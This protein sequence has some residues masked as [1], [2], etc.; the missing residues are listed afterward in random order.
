M[1]SAIGYHFPLPVGGS[2]PVETVELGP[3]AASQTLRLFWEVLLEKWRGASPLHSTPVVVAH[4]HGQKESLERAVEGGETFNFSEVDWMSSSVGV[5]YRT[6]DPCTVL[7]S[8]DMDVRRLLLV[9]AA[10]SF[11]VAAHVEALN[12]QSQCSD[13]LVLSEAGERIVREIER[14]LQ[15]ERMGI[16]RTTLYSEGIHLTRARSFA[17]RDFDFHQ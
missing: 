6:S 7:A 8:S 14:A 4:R 3:E 15:C 16:L 10:T 5:T 13:S 11:Y 1:F 9:S 2:I 17:I 12:F